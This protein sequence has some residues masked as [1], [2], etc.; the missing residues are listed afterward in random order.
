MKPEDIIKLRTSYSIYIESE[1]IEKQRRF[2]IHV[3]IASA[4][5]GMVC[6]LL[7]TFGCKATLAPGGAYNSGSTNVVAVKADMAFFVVDSA[8]DLAY[9]TIDAAFKF[10][11]DNRDML[12]RQSRQIKQELDRMRPQAVV[13]NGKY[14]TARA[15][16]LA[17]PLPEN[18][19]TLQAILAEIQKLSATATAVLP[20]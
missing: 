12:W 19:T 6:I 8:Y 20:K 10:E 5:I 14:L 13:I 11:K 9:A 4:V 18:L 15:A 3:A 1:K 17:N 2:C 7:M 16:Y